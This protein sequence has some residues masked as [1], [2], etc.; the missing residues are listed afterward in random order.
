M[1]TYCLT[2]DLHDDAEL[3]AEYK[4]YHQPE[5]VWPEVVRSIRTMGVVSEQIYL[6]GTRLVMILNTTDGFSFEDKAAADR[7]NPT[8]KQ[9]E[10]LMW[11]YQRPLPGAR[12][13]E[14]WIRM[15]KIFEVS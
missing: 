3:I 9:W 13:G 15:E 14:K 2:L 10:E 12:P 6:L 5:N 1:K 7:Q 8:M 11:K 4:R